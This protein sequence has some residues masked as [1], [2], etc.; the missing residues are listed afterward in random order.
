MNVQTVLTNRKVQVGIASALLAG[1]GATVFYIL[2]KRRKKTQT[3][4]YHIVADYTDPQRSLFD[5]D[6]VY[7]TNEE[8]PDRML[9]DPTPREAPFRQSLKFKEALEELQKRAND[10]ENQQI[11]SG[12]YKD[13]IGEP[14]SSEE[15]ARFNVFNTPEPKD[16]WDY[17]DELASRT[18]HEPYI[19]HV[20]E[21]M[22]NDSGFHQSTV[23]YYSGDDIM[24]N[25]EDTA[26]Y[27]FQKLMGPL[28]FG[29]GSDD[30][31]V[32]YIRNESF[33][34]EWEVIY[35]PGKFSIEIIGDQYDD[36]DEAELKHS[37][38]KFRDD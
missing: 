8:I 2:H 26:I 5:E 37:V 4:T 19:I 23:T 29:H 11:A 24:A 27:D 35:H 7:I 14:P 18:P 15:E 28:R 20:S 30:M 22:E 36:K 25:E 10:E 38:Q 6:V 34:S 33:K 13:E 17:D 21:F 12:E 3:Q 32:V 9:I 16:V 1:G 31:G